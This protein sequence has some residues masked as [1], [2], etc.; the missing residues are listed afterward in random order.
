MNHS[1]TLT[2]QLSKR[3]CRIEGGFP[4]SSNLVYAAECTKCKLIYVGQTGDSLSN[5]FNRHRSDITHYPDRCELPKHFH[6]N[7]K[8]AF[9]TDLQVSVLENIKGSEAVRKHKEDKWITRLQTIQPLG[10]NLS[11]SDFGTIYDALFS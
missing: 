2:N 10:L 8:C 3:S 1:K 5:R 4:H 11:V 7:D 6:Q 9:E